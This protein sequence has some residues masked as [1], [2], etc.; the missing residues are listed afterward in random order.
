MLTT[1]KASILRISLNFLIFIAVSWK[2]IK[3]VNIDLG[4]SDEKVESIEDPVEKM[5]LFLGYKWNNRFFFN[6]AEWNK[7]TKDMFSRNFLICFSSWRLS[8]GVHGIRLGR[9]LLLKT[10]MI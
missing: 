10:V 6:K 5:I 2:N 1:R 3:A 7:G 9:N 8:L 4:F